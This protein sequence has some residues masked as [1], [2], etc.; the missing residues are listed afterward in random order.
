MTT[1]GAESSVDERP[2][3]WLCRHGETEWSRSGRHT[4]TSD[5]DLTERGAR[6][7]VLAGH[8]LRSERFGLVL[9]S[10]LRR[11]RETA[12]LAGF[13]GAQVERNAVEW[14]YGEYEGLTTAE[15]R[16]RDPGWTIW[17]GHVPG[18]ERAEDVGARADRIVAR[19]RAAGVPTLLF[20]HGHFLRV[21]AARWL[22]LPPARGESLK[23]DT[24]TVSQLGWERDAPAVVR[25]NLRPPEPVT[26]AGPA[27]TA[28]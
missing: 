27:G 20:S 12:R 23:L 10:P 4:G 21:L 26:G 24:A 28:P 25:W 7:A 19:V 6:E 17:H 15:A 13:P 22:G 18:G 8:V 3:L 1:P 11:A 2:P 5:L 14:D 9:T 16:E